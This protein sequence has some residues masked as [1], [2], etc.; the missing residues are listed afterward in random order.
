MQPSVSTPPPLRSPAA[1]DL[2]AC[3]DAVADSMREALL[4]RS[5]SPMAGQAGLCAAAVFLPDGRL[6]AAGRGPQPLLAGSLPVAVYGILGEF[7]PAAMEPGDGYIC[8]DPWRGGSRLPEVVLLR[9]VFADG[10]VQAFVA[11][12]LH[13]QDV[14]GMT[15]GSLP[16]AA[17]SVHQ[18]GL[19]IPPL[20]LFRQ[21]QTD[22]ALF[23]LLCTNSRTPDPLAADMRTQW[24]VL[25]AAD[26]AIQLVL[27]DVEGFRQQ[28]EVAIAEAEGA[29]R[30]AL[31]A[32]P[33][34]DYRFAAAREEVPGG[35]PLRVPVLLRKQGD[36]LV[37]DLTGCA[38]Q[39]TGPG[40]ASRGAVWSAIADFARALAPDAAGNAGCTA[41]LQ[42]R[43]APGTI[44]DPAFPAAVNGSA[45]VIEL[46]SEALHGAWAQAQ[47]TGAPA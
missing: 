17:T 20:R 44:V 32:V 13:H 21:G 36:R 38:A 34:G 25:L 40:N 9:P 11:C 10:A 2:S 33:D 1:H 18:E 5:T 26:E 39:S 12:I 24:S 31:R 8:N 27:D 42:L 35:E 22:A 19:R 23:R 3:L 7:A 47:R 15:P 29:V 28:C 6:V 45:P 16:P 46:L 4:T 41:P 43:S 30:A 14:G 37:V